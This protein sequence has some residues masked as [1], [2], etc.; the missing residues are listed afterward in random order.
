MKKPSL[1]RKLLII[2][3]SLFALGLLLSY[4][5]PY[6]NPCDFWPLAFFGL[7]FPYLLISNIVFLLIWIFR[8]S[9]YFLL[10]LI[11]LLLGY[12][13]IP[14]YIQWNPHLPIEGESIKVLSFNVRVFDLYLWTKEKSTR[15]KIFDFLEKEQPDILCLQEFYQS[16]T[17]NHKYPFKTLDTLKQ[18]LKARNYHVDYTTTIKGVNHWG[19]ITFSKYPIINKNRVPFAIKDD[20][21]CIYSDIKIKDKILRVFNAHLASIKLNKHDYKAMQQINNNSYSENFDKELLLI[22]KLRYGFERRALQADSIQ[23]SIANSPYPVLVCGDFNDTPSSYAYHEI[24]GDLN[25]AY[26]IAGNGFGRTYIGEFP[27]YRIDYILYSDELKA[28]KYT[29]HPQVL[30]DHHPISAQL[31]WSQ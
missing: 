7:A 26:Q 10:P 20:N 28:L 9:R 4:A 1:I 24:K 2:I 14:N 30:S 17:V 3:N 29:T 12:Q 27:S 5:A 16:D 8:G 25:D 21:I 11:V 22:E 13:S 19:I 23:K 18:F 15:N 31:K 6:I